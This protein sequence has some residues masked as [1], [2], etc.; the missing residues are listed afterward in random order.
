M[1]EIKSLQESDFSGDAFKAVDRM[2]VLFESPWCQGCHAVEK[3]ILGMIE[4]EAQG[5]QWGKVDVSTQQEV[6]QRFGVLSLPTLLVFH[7]GQLK[8]RMVGKIS[9]EKLL[10]AI[11]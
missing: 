10:K 8:E 4:T 5:C 7:E 1:P 3:M 9:K 11:K 2:A 6:A